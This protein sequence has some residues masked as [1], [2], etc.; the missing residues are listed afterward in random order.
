M[1]E[2][3]EKFKEIMQFHIE[4]RKKRQRTDFADFIKERCNI[5]G[6]EALAKVA[7]NAIP[8]IEIAMDDSEI[9]IGASKKGGFPDLPPSISYP[10]MNEFSEEQKKW[11]Q[12]R[13]RVYK[14]EPDGFIT[15]PKSAMQLLGQF[16]LSE[17]APFDK[18]NLLPKTGMLYFFWSGELPC[19]T[20]QISPFKVIYWNGDISELRRTAPAIPYYDKYFTEPLPSAKLAFE[21]CKNEYDIE[22]VQKELGEE[23]D[24]YPDYNIRNA[25]LFGY[26]TG[27]NIDIPRGD[28]INLY[29]S[30]YRSGCICDIYWYIRKQD[31]AALNFDNTI[32]VSDLD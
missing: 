16:N 32:F 12:V 6:Y 4:Q 21:Y 5:E 13:P 9:P 26:P 19:Y 17:S 28:I 15:H 25:K 1:S 18:D 7:K 31:L 11:V 22:R 20:G 14:T 24:Y 3:L 29:Q 30:G 8:A 23:Y 2:E 10:T 27:V